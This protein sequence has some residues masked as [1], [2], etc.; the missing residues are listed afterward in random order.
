MG[1]RFGAV[2]GVSVAAVAIALAAVTGHPSGISATV[3]PEAS[4]GSSALSAAANNCSTLLVVG[5]RGSG[6]SYSAGTLGMGPE[7]FAAYSQIANRVPGT[8][9]F[10]LPYPAVAVLPVSQL[11]SAY[12]QS[13]SYGDHMLFQYVSQEVAACPYQRIALIGYSQGAQVIGDTLKNL[14]ASQRALT[15]QVLLFGDPRF[16]PAISGI[17]RGNYN[18]RLQGFFGARTI[19]SLWYSKM[20]DYCALY[21][22]I[23]NYNVANIA[24]C[25]SAGTGC[26]H[27]EYANSGTA[28]FAG[29]LAANAIAALPHLGPPPV[30]GPKTYRYYVYHTCAN[31]ACGLHVRTGPGYTNYAITRTLVDGD[32]VDI[33]CQTR[34][35]SVSG[36]D[37]SSSNVWDKLIQGDYVADFYIDT[38]GMTGSF[39]PPIPQC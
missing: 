22:P 2:V 36:L 27:Y 32:P 34:G 21:D 37:G 31:G 1:G 25:A 19:A 11:G 38:P 18:P 8:V 14:T 13:L 30:P 3:K 6:E 17:D 4:M 23:C 33:V 10:G 26:A 9:P 39:S 16:N 12:W 15:A 29:A 24:K 7:V 28:A 20:R 35:E 5:V